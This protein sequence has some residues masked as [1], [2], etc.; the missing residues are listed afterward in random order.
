MLFEMATGAMPFQRDTPMQTM[1][2]VAFDDTPSLRAFRPNLTLELDRI[3]R[4]CLQKNPNDRY[5]DA[6]SLVVELRVL[7]RETETGLNK[8][9]TIREQLNSFWDR[10]THLK[11]PQLAWLSIGFV[12][13][14]C[15]LYFMFR[16]ISLGGFL[17]VGVVGLLGYRHLRN[18]SHRLLDRF[19][20]K[21]SKMPEVRFIVVRG[22]CITVAVDR[23]VG[24]L[25]GRINTRLNEC[26]RELFFGDP[27]T[28]VIRPDLSEEETRELISGGGVQYVRDHKSSE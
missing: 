18:Q 9:S 21:V 7:R 25:Y 14:G 26:N 10:I 3:V 11:R 27:W 5:P 17:L 12:A 4:R 2:A 6:R 20:R 16:G 19:C 8:I 28:V 24:Q 13:A 15:A 1:Q 23:V 22:G